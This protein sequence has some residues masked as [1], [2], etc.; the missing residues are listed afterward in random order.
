MDNY[1]RAMI[2]AVNRNCECMALARR[3]NAISARRR[4]KKGLFGRRK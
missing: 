1:E 4:R 3:L 2:A